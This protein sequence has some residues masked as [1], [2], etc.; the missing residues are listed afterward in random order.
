[1]LTTLGAAPQV[2]WRE[3]VHESRRGGHGYRTLG[4]VNLVRG[5]GERLEI[6]LHQ[7]VTGVGREPPGPPLER[8]FIVV[9]GAY[10][11]R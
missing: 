9:D 7:H 10:Q 3:G 2:L 6:V 4:M 11:R 8:H 5:A 1:M